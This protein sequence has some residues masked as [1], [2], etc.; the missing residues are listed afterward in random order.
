MSSVDTSLKSIAE[1]SVQTGAGTVGS[2]FLAILARVKRSAA[3]GTRQGGNPAETI[4]RS[5][6]RKPV[7]EV[8]SLPVAPSEK[9]K[10]N[11]RG[12][13]MHK[14]DETP[15]PIL[16]DTMPQV[17]D[18]LPDPSRWKI[19]QENFDRIEDRMKGAQTF[20]Q[21]STASRTNSNADSNLNSRLQA[22]RPLTGSG[23]PLET[24]HATPANHAITQEATKRRS[25]RRALGAPQLEGVLRRR[26]M[27]CSTGF[28]IQ[29]MKN[30][31][32]SGTRQ[33]HDQH[34]KCRRARHTEWLFT[35]KYIKNAA[36]REQC[37]R[38]VS[39]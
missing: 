29:I 2:L 24:E 19:I 27:Y 39:V 25:K 4:E 34:G 30:G 5:M 22:E 16:H 21:K 26:Q 31:R 20:Q 13:S 38:K 11:R 1:Q 17:H 7:N 32:V 18:R 23:T 37:R 12:A 28:H 6:S 33:D 9:L 8:S 10:F 15:Q 3:A 14:S 36:K 35:C